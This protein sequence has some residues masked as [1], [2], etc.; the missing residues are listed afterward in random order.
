MGGEILPLAL[1]VAFGS[2]LG[3]CVYLRT[4]L[5]RSGQDE[6][7]M[8]DRVRGAERW[9][10]VAEG[11]LV[12][13]RDQRIAL[14]NDAFA[15]KIGQPA[16]ALAGR[17]A[18]DLPWNGRRTAAEEKY[19]WVRA[20]DEGTT[21]MGKVLGLQSTSLGLRKLSVNST[22]IFGEDGV[23]SSRRPGHVR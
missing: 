8:P 7:V 5:R 10:T 19:P 18:S 21:L 2:F 15:R 20:I 22:P 23:Y 17:R 14:A 3:M 11:V 1:F 4:V 6:K 13:D 9:N 16:S 12:L